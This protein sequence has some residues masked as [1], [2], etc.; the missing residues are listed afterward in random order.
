MW[1]YRERVEKLIKTG[2]KYFWREAETEMKW[3]RDRKK[4]WRKKT[5][6]SENGGLAGGGGKRE[7]TLRERLNIFKTCK[8]IYRVLRA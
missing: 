4:N 5:Q 1:G 6:D 3:I 2:K 8:E 7:K